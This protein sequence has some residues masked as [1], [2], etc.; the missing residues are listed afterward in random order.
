MNRMKPCYR[1]PK[2]V[3]DA[4]G[5]V[6]NDEVNQNQ[7]QRQVQNDGVSGDEDKNEAFSAVSL[8]SDDIDTVVLPADQ[9]GQGA[10]VPPE[11]DVEIPVRPVRERH[12]PRWLEDYEQYQ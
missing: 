1:H 10:E 12:V 11:P 8:L 5:V 3:E 9:V 6:A 2:A 4:D 7:S